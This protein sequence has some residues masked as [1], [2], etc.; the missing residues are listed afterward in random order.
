MNNLKKS[1]AVALCVL[2]TACTTVP[3]QTVIHQTTLVAVVPT[4]TIPTAPILYI[5]QL[6]EADKGNPGLVAQYYYAS[7][8]QLK[9]YAS[10]LEKAIAAYQADAADKTTIQQLQNQLNA[11]NA[12]VTQMQNVVPA[13]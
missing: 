4:L 7:I 8:V 1:L 2:A 3:T 5:D 9:G 12:Q 10:D 6:T 13:K 11:T